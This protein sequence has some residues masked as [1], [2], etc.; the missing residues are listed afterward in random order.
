MHKI[1]QHKLNTSCFN[2][3]RP[4]LLID[5]Y[6]FE[7]DKLNVNIIFIHLNNFFFIH[8]TTL[9]MSCIIDRI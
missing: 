6:D 9:V 3:L 5:N 8:N 7:P 4:H 1:S 2:E